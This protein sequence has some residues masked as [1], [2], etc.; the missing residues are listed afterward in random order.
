MKPFPRPRAARAVLLRKWKTHLP[1]TKQDDGG[2]VLRQ[3]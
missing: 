2:D 3:D 1:A